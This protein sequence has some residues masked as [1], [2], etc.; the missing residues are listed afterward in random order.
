MSRVNNFTLGFIE[1]PLSLN[2][3]IEHKATFHCE[4]VSADAFSW[5]MNG[6]SLSDFTDLHAY[7]DFI[8]RLSTLTVTALPEYNAT[9][10]QCVAF[11]IS[12][13]SRQEVTPDA[14]LLI[15]G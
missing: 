8:G 2:V 1:E 5:R 14:I 15:Q 3:T 11:F 12:N 10:I 4:H 9:V 6:T 13:T 7:V